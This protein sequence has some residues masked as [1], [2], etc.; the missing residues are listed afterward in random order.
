[1]ELQY[2][3]AEEFKDEHGYYVFPFEVLDKTPGGSNLGRIEWHIELV[4]SKKKDGRYWIEKLLVW[5]SQT[6]DE[7]YPRN[8]IWEIECYAECITSRNY[9]GESNSFIANVWR[10]FFC[11]VHKNLIM[12]AYP[13]NQHSQLKINVGSSI[14]IDADFE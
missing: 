6:R 9:Q 8:I 12:T 10:M 5:P 14:S 3:S 7:R 11:E 13:R 1:M 4:R 2:K